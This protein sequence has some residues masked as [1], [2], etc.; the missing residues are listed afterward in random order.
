[1]L[2]DTTSPS[3][4]VFVIVLETEIIIGFGAVVETFSLIV[5]FVIGA[6]AFIIGI[7]PFVR[8]PLLFAETYPLIARELVTSAFPFGATVLASYLMGVRFLRAR[9]WICGEEYAWSVSRGDCDC[10]ALW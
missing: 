9:K 7:Q 3:S 5:A 1:M 6:L 2:G 4:H 10:E 8:T